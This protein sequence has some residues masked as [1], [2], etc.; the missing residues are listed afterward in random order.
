MRFLLKKKKE[1]IENS[2]RINSTLLSRDNNNNSRVILFPHLITT[3][4]IDGAVGSSHRRSR[5][6]NHGRRW[7]LARN[8]LD[9]HAWPV[10]LACCTIRP[11]LKVN[12]KKDRERE[13]EARHD[14]HNYIH[15]LHN[16]G[17]P[18]I[19]RRTCTVSPWNLFGSHAHPGR[20]PRNRVKIIRIIAW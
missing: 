2:W 11:G 5:S 8:R 14:L 4:I 17:Y 20:P 6:G 18:V 15:A 1:N 10:L 13:R 12:V 19:W 16:P 7:P 9:S 3:S